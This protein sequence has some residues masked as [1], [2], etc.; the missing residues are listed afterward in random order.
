ML[1]HTTGWPVC[2]GTAKSG[3]CEAGVKD[4]NN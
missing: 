3:Y 4:I 2:S 1:R